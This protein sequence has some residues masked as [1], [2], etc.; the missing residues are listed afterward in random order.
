MILQP[1]IVEITAIHIEDMMIWEEKNKKN[2][3]K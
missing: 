2:I 1:V 3:H